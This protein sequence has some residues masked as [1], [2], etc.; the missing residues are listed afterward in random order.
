MC[1]GDH[2]LASGRGSTYS[3]G[4][5]STKDR[6]AVATVRALRSTIIIIVERVQNLM[7]R[8]VDREAKSLLTAWFLFERSSR[9]ETTN[10]S[11]M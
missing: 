1:E 10:L 6:N 9:R 3:I 7:G 11:K 5:A 8:D 2:F 4:L